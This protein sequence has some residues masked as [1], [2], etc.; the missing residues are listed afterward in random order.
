MPPLLWCQLYLWISCCRLAPESSVRSCKRICYRVLAINVCIPTVRPST[1]A[2]LQSDVTQASVTTM[3]ATT[4]SG[5]QSPTTSTPSLFTSNQL[6]P[7]LPVTN[8]QQVDEVL[9]AAS[10][11]QSL[12]PT[13]V[14]N[15]IA[16]LTVLYLKHFLP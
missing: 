3:A 2:T 16:L 6:P 10:P 4:T 5:N 11:I 1:P 13:A 9:S 7:T 12:S 14:N 8:N 15:Q